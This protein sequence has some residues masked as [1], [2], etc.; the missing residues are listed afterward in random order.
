MI[1]YRNSVTASQLS[2]QVEQLLDDQRQ[3]I[4]VLATLRDT[5]QDQAQ[6]HQLKQVNLFMQVQ[7]RHHRGEYRYQVDEDPGTF[8][9]DQLDPADKEHL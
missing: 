7:Y 4:L 6:R 8:S 2:T 5:T 9:A 3:Q 1:A